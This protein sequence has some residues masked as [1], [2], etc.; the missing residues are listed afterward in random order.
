MAAG[1]ARLGSLSKHAPGRRITFPSILPLFTPPSQPRLEP[2][3]EGE[4]LAS[5]RTFKPVRPRRQSTTALSRQAIQTRQSMSRSLDLGRPTEEELKQG[6]LGMAPELAAWWGEQGA[7]GAMGGDPLQGW[8][9]R[10]QQARAVYKSFLMGSQSPLDPFEQWALEDKYA[11]LCNFYVHISMD[12]FSQGAASDWRHTEG[13][14][15]SITCAEELLQ[16]LA[17][18]CH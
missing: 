4:Q 10:E 8:L 1:M 11:K 16:D 15:G 17:S 3:Q 7:A 5:S 2:V 18:Q 14:R 9:R 6:Q 12:G 13:L